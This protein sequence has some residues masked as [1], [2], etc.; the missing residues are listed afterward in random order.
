[1]NQKTLRNEVEKTY[2]RWLCGLVDC[3]L[4]L[5]CED[6]LLELYSKEFYSLVPNDDNRVEDGLKL[7]EMFGE[8]LRLSAVNISRPCTVLEM[9]IALAGRMAYIVWQ[10]NEEDKTPRMFWIL[11]NNLRLK[12]RSVGNEIVIDH[13]L[14]RRYASDGDGGLFPLK[15]P[16]RD[17]TKVEIWYQMQEYLRSSI[18]K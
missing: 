10:P 7:R 3:K 14:E 1:M 11:I 9:M 2:F 6:L 5:E 12:P 8:E 18:F 4:N 16:E 17:Q 15:N 13:F